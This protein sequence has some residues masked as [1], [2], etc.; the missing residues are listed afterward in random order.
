MIQTCVCPHLQNDS[1]S[2]DCVTQSGAQFCN[3]WL[4]IVRPVPQTCIFKTLF[5]GLNFFYY[6]PSS[7]FPFLGQFWRLLSIFRTGIWC[8]KTNYESIQ[9]RNSYFNHMLTRAYVMAGVGR[10]KEKVT[11]TRKICPHSAACIN[12]LLYTRLKLW[13]IKLIVCYIKL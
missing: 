12:N 8:L 3:S 9:W 13:Y 10:V 2:K 11:L 6:P 5:T 1:I 4:F 7:S